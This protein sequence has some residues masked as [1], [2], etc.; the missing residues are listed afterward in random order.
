MVEYIDMITCNEK[1]VR[2]KIEN[3]YACTLLETLE[4][5]L[6]Q[7]KVTLSLDILIHLFTRYCKC[8]FLLPLLSTC[9]PNIRDNIWW[10]I[11]DLCIGPYRD[12]TVS[13]SKSFYVVPCTIANFSQNLKKEIEV[14]LFCYSLVLVEKCGS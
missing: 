3:G 2:G 6:S 9:Q 13:I 5:L 7:N 1:R 11:H 8:I 12:I 4:I 10:S 14:K